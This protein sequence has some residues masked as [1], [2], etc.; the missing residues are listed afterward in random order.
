LS[1]QPSG[2]SGG[3]GLTGQPVFTAIFAFYET[4]SVHELANFFEMPGDMGYS[5]LQIRNNTRNKK[6][7]LAWMTGQ[8]EI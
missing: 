8:N 6:K 2:A 7:T 5:Q 4:K 3:A 1:S